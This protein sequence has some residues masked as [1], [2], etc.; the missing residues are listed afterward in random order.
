M[1]V[2][3]AAFPVTL[4]V[5][6]QSQNQ[7]AKSNKERTV[8]S[9]KEEKGS[10]RNVML[11][12]ESNDKP[13]EI[14]IGL[15]SNVGGTT[16]LQ[17]GNPVNFHFWPE[18]PHFV[19]R[20]D[21]GTQRSGLKS[22]TATAIEDGAIGYAVD[23]WDNRG[24]DKFQVKGSVNSNHFGLLNGTVA[25]SG[26]IKDGWKY[27]ASVFLNFDPGTFDASK[28][29]PK[30]YSD[31]T[32]LYK[33]GLTKDYRTANAKGSMT[34]FYRYSNHK[35]LINFYAPYT[36]FADGSVKE[37]NGFKIGNDSYLLSSGVMYIKDAYT[38]EIAPCS[39]VESYGN[40]AH[41]VEL[42]WNHDLD[43]GLKL[44]WNTNF[45]TSVASVNSY[46]MSSVQ[47]AGSKYTYLDGKPY[48]GEYVQQAMYMAT[49]PTHIN[50]FM[51]TI[52]AGKRSGAHEWKA[53]LNEWHY[54]AHRYTTEVSSYYMAV[55]K[56]PSTL[57]LANGGSN[58]Y[59][60]MFGFNS[61]M[62]YHNGDQN[63]IAIFGT[64]NWTIS[65]DLKLNTG[66]RLEW[67]TMKG[68][69]IRTADRVNG[70]LDL[71]KTIPFKDHW[72]DKNIYVNPTYRIMKGFGVQATLMYAEQGGIMG[73][74]NTGADKDIKQSK[75]KLASGGVYWNNRWFSLV[76]QLSYIT[77]NNYSGNSNF[78]HPATGLVARTVVAYDVQ[79]LGWTTDVVFHPVKWFNMHALL[80]LQDPQYKNYDGTLN[81]SDGTTRDFDFD[82]KTVTGMSKTLIELD[83]SF[84]FSGWRIWLSARYFS[85]T[86]A[87]LANTLAFEGHWETFGGVSYRINKNL[88][89]NV[90]VTNILGQRGAKG[91]ISGTD[92]M[93]AEEAKQRVGTEGTVMSGTY[94]LP[95]TV[96]FGLNFSF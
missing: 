37:Y 45:R 51:S 96:K 63:K 4:P 88:N 19:W 74:Y 13:R 39:P 32:K 20:N 17:N 8:P 91:T 40:H 3:L 71:T 46:V 38:G 57:I 41:A 42:L 92:L 90:S 49:R 14:N 55:E 25:V 24:T 34:L 10:D 81:F 43:N 64:D 79:T 58:A 21:A 69:R 59:D 22:I 50:T 86:Q 29:Y 1:A 56:D 18:M 28:N 78:M 89:A 48:T 67:S 66:A 68:N 6:A 44:T 36:Y 9:E 62:E 12:A 72:F 61:F 15:P 83:P 53:G 33:V 5:M 31:N 52:T 76:S 30:Y 2:L 77:R 95:F 75:I 26:P 60:G 65:S 82:G 35:G 16:V 11:N 93:T 7:K 85:K 80:T 94:I 54:H 73:N 87:N 47:E 27:V 23:S 84:M 70:M